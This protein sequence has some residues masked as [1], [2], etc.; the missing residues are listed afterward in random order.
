MLKLKSQYEESQDGV[1]ALGLENKKLADDVRDL[2]YQV[3]EAD[4]FDLFVIILF[5]FI[6]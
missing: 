5:L 2:M 1:A 6:N 4:F 3:S